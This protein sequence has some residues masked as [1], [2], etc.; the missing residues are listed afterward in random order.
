MEHD[1]ICIAYMT[2]EEA[3]KLVVP[4]E[5]DA[6]KGN[7]GKLLCICGSDK[8][9]GAAMLCTEAAYRMGA[10]I[11]RLASVRSVTDKAVLRVPEIVT[12]PLPSA[13][14]GTIGADSTDI[15]EEALET[16]TACVIGCGL[17]ISGDTENIVRCILRC[18]KCPLIV[19][20]DA[21]NIISKD[22]NM[23]ARTA[24]QTVITP[25]V[26]EMSRLTG[27]SAEMIQ[28][29]RV[30][31]AV[32][33]AERYGTA[34]VLKGSE[35]VTAGTVGGKTSGSRIS[36]RR[37]SD[38]KIVERDSAGNASVQKV[39]AI[40]NTSGNPGM[41]KGGSGDVLAGVIGGRAAQGRDLFESAAL[42]VYIHGKAGDIAAEEMSE[43]G[44]M[45]TDVIDRLA[46]VF[47]MK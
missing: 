33:F 6:H 24:A 11:V 32:S 26:G 43:Y 37:I 38:G 17:G 7:F 5:R 23:L 31:A 40:V 29:D 2:H 19:D 8:M 27:M 3:K 9:P 20:A 25:H 46:E 10:G 44:I 14:C 4:R 16:A 36:V 30:R 1:D 35:T 34:V 13:P 39:S 22:T 18:A 15:L 12:L 42:G 41:A 21:L 47:T 28:S 45:P